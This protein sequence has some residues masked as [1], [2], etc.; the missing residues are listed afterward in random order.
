MANIL[1]GYLKY[2]SI[3]I[4]IFAI[5][6]KYEISSDRSSTDKKTLIVTK[7]AVLEYNRS[8]VFNIITNINKYSMVCY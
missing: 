7:K 3:I 1:S 6:Y 5:L 2:F 8:Y 4:I